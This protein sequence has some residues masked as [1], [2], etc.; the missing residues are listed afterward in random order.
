MIRAIVGTLFLFAGAFVYTYNTES[1]GSKLVFRVEHDNR[2]FGVGEDE[3]A[4]ILLGIGVLMLALGAFRWL[5]RNTSVVE[6]EGDR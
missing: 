1:S 2:V 3:T 4:A 5:R 6:Q